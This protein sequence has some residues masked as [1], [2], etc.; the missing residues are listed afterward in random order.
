MTAT[1]HTEHYGLSQH[2]EDDHPP[3]TGDYNGDMRKIRRGDTCGI[4]IRHV[5]PLRTRWKIIV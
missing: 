1:S 2:T 5:S 3:H 4:A